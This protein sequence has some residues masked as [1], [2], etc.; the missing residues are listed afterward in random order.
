M[1]SEPNRFEVALGVVLDIWREHRR[2]DMR[3]HASGQQGITVRLRRGDACTAQCTTGAANVL[4]LVWQGARSRPDRRH[5][6]L[7]RVVIHLIPEGARFLLRQ[8]LGSLIN[9]IGMLCLICPVLF[10]LALQCRR[11][12]ELEPCPRNEVQPVTLVTPTEAVTATCCSCG[13]YH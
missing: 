10:E 1:R 5:G 2:S 3:P 12:L 11:F 4:P 6:L 13:G 9:E 8:C 7:N